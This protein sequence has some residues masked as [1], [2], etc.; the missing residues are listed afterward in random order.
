MIRRLLA[1]FGLFVLIFLAYAHYVSR[2][3]VLIKINDTDI[4][5]SLPIAL[6][7]LLIISL[8]IHWLLLGFR[9]LRHFKKHWQH[10]RMLKQ[11]QER[12]VAL[13]QALDIK[14]TAEHRAREY[15]DSLHNQGYSVF[16]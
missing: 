15:I 1:Y 7:A 2:A 6:I 10:S 4:K 12:G 9:W 14:V 16:L 11:S 13:E 8:I 5:A 3:W